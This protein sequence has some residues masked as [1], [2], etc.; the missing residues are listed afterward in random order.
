MEHWVSMP[1][2]WNIGI[3][4]SAGGPYSTAG[5]TGVYKYKRAA[6]IRPSGMW[7]E[8]QAGWAVL[9]GAE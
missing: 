6:A 2:A 7:G 8:L 5:E 3:T 9:L 4:D 1:R